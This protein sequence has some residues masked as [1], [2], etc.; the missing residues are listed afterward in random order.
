MDQ[1][2]LSKALIWLVLCLSAFSGCNR[3]EHRAH[4]PKQW[5]FKL[6]SLPFQ[7]L[8][9]KIPTTHPQWRNR[10]LNSA[11]AALWSSQHCF[12][13]SAAFEYGLWNVQLVGRRG[14]DCLITSHVI[15]TI[16]IPSHFGLSLRKSNED[17]A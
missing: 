6:H 5:S 8:P 12:C 2:Q 9:K 4:Y 17:R 7:I 10:E 16:P 15:M 14:L 3:E 13:V 1:D 11:S